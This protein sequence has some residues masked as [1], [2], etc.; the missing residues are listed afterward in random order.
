MRTQR[1]RL[2]PTALFFDANGS[3]VVIGRRGRFDLEGGAA[4]AVHERLAPHLD[5]RTSEADLLEAVGDSRRAWIA[6]YLDQLRRCGA[7]DDTDAL[8]ATELPRLRA[9]LANLGETFRV[10]ARIQDRRLAVWLDDLPP[11]RRDSELLRL[12]FVA[13]DQLEERL[14]RDLGHPLRGHL[15]V[16]LRSPEAARTDEAERLLRSTWARWLA[17][18]ALRVTPDDRLAVYQLADSG[19]IK[20]LARLSRLDGT[21]LA[22]FS[23]ILPTVTLAEVPQLPLAVTRSQ[24]AVRGYFATA[25]GLRAETTALSLRRESLAHSELRAR[26]DQIV[27]TLLDCVSDAAVGTLRWPQTADDELIVAASRKAL[28]ARLEERLVTQKLAFATFAWEEVDLFA[29]TQSPRGLA[30]LAG[31]VGT[32]TAHLPGR[33]AFWEGFHLVAT[34]GAPDEISVSR[35]LPLALAETLAREAWRCFSR[36]NWPENFLRPSV[37]I[38]PSELG[39]AERVMSNQRSLGGLPRSNFVAIGRV[40]ALGLSTWIG[41]LVESKAR[42]DLDREPRAT[43][44]P[45]R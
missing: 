43:N 25:I 17:I 35:K 36:P 12:G 21:G 39:I 38:T 20:L 45:R 7:V 9:V 32:R 2:D 41:A 30:Y 13:P 28:F 14:A 11:T 31:V 5:G 22:T 1:P 37:A 42:F 23:R 33:V 15:V 34:S 16:I 27:F 6:N 40:C 26:R 44:E 8:A 10:E 24:V 4:R 3:L 18:H 19:G 29:I